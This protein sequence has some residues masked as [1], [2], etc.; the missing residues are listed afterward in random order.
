MA[1]Q[2]SLDRYGVVLVGRSQGGTAPG[3]QPQ[4][5]PINATE[6]GSDPLLMAGGGQ[7]RATGHQALLIMHWNAEGEQQK[8]LALQQLLKTKNKQTNKQTK[9]T[10]AAPRRPIS[11]ARTDSPSGQRKYTVLT[12]QTDPKAECLRLR[13]RL[14]FVHPLQDVALHQ[15]LPLSSVCCLLYPGGSL[16]LCYVVLPS[17]AW[18]SS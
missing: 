17:S 2:L 5:G 8:K 10:S 18:S 11:T 1:M 14:G 4:K 16:L 7:S 6:C 15:C 9:S 3:P 12:E 13:L